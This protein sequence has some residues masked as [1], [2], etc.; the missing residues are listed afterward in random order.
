[1]AVPVFK[2]PC[3]LVSLV[4]AETYRLVLKQNFNY[5]ELIQFRE[6]RIVICILTCTLKC[7]ATR[8]E[9]K[10]SKIGEFFN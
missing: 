3:L 9:K 10:Y 7:S 8:L 6:I 2:Y 1:M 5:L 4:T